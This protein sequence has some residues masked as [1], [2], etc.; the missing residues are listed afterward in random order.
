MDK[1]A[2]K[3]TI[4]TSVAKMSKA[5]SNPNR[6]E[7]LDLLANGEQSVE[8]V[9]TATDIS[10]ANASHHLQILKNAKMATA[11]KEKNFIFYALANHEVYVVWKV[12]RDLAIIQDPEVKWTLREFR[13][14]KKSENGI[15]Y[16]EISKRKDIVLL[17][18]RPT[19]EFNAGHITEARSIPI[20]ELPNR[21]NELPKNKTIIIYCRGTFCTY[22]DEAVQLL[23]KNDFNAIRL[24]ESYLDVELGNKN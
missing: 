14:K 6:L 9:A 5:F 15:S 13:E 19:N 8:Q 4:Y 22:A 12:I 16:I 7:I 11:R 10:I 17:D 24:E 20:Q 18:V 1:R 3:N 21:F 23:K 2:F